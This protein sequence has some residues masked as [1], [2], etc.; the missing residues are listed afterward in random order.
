VTKTFAKRDVN[1]NWYATLC[2]CFRN[3]FLAGVET[4]VP[5][6]KKTVAKRDV[7]MATDD[8][9]MLF[10]CFLGN[11]FLFPFK[12]LQKMNLNWCQ[13]VLRP[14]FELV[15]FSIGFGFC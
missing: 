10:I 15:V 14:F 8:F 6:N 12:L 11:S 5:L 7:N 1:D 9:I 13:L 2:G 3:L 4:C